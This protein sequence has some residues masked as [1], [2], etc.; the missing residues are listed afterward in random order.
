MSGFL[1]RLD[2][3]IRLL[4]F[5][6]FGALL[7]LRDLRVFTFALPEAQRQIPKH[8]LEKGW[9]GAFQFG[10]A[11]GT[12]VRTYLPSTAPYLLLLALILVG[13]SGLSFLAAGI[14]FGLGRSLTPLLRS[15]SSEGEEWDQLMNQDRSI[16]E[17]LSGLLV[18]TTTLGLHFYS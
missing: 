3:L 1:L 17:G 16:I 4:A 6:L 11:L 15:R 12:G 5:S 7:I 10:F 9:I 2:S 13:P 18:V 14:G 8:V